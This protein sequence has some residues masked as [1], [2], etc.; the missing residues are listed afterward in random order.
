M[1]PAC[2]PPCQPHG[3]TADPMAPPFLHVPIQRYGVV[4]YY[5]KQ[6]TSLLSSSQKVCGSPVSEV[7][8]VGYALGRV[9]WRG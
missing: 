5:D 6:Q 9:A 7:D 3:H 1:K 8:V 2:I 4:H